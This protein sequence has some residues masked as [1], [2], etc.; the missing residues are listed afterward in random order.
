MDDPESQPLA[1]AEAPEGGYGT[2]G[3]GHDHGGDHSHEH[4]G[5]GHGGHGHGGHGDQGG[6]GHGHGGHGHG[7]GGHEDH[8]DH[9]HD[10]GGHDHSGGHG[11]DHGGHDHGHDHGGHGHGGGG[12]FSVKGPGC[13][14]GDDGK[15]THSPPARQLRAQREKEKRALKAAIALCVCFMIVEVVGGYLANSLAVMTDA[16]HLLTDVASLALSLWALNAAEWPA[17][18]QEPSG[19]EIQATFGWHRAEV[20]GTLASVTSIWFLTGIIMW[21]A[22]GRTWSI[23]ACASSQVPDPCTCVMI[24]GPL[25]LKLGVLG[26]MVNISMA[27]ILACGGNPKVQHAHSHD[28]GGHGGHGGHG[29]SHGGHDEEEGESTTMNVE[30][31]FLHA[32]GD[33]LN[34]LGVIVAG[35]VIWLCQPAEHESTSW[36]NLADPACSFLFGVV[37][38][39]TS[40]GLGKQMI[41]I[42]MESCPSSVDYFAVLRTVRDCPGVVDVHDLHVWSLTRDLTSLSVHVRIEKTTDAGKVLQV[43][44]RRV[45][46]RHGIK[47]STVQVEAVDACCA[48][49]CIDTM[50]D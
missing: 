6:H 35:L 19:G 47:H 44:Q 2:A 17:G 13:V 5:H 14:V 34:S 50:H 32:L 15:V 26:L 29:H 33:C 4:G 49:E 37:T 11:H 41:G 28:G 8:G 18:L 7:H 45:G 38:I 36:Y 22:V 23:I 42:L 27:G 10:H 46:D 12:S 30:S 43:V 39:A 48:T 25:M 24:N 16:A 31:A 21:E 9:G 3:H 1:A 40:L 20:L